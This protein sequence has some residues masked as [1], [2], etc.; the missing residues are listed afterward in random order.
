MRIGKHNI[1]LPI[2]N[3]CD[4][5]NVWMSKPLSLLQIEPH[6]LQQRVTHFNGEREV[7]SS[8]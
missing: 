2:C 3:N 6:F 8:I 4:C 5:Y 7:N 1:D